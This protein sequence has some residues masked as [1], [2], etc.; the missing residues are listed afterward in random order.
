MKCDRRKFME[1]I[2]R[3]RGQ[4]SRFGNFP[5]VVGFSTREWDCTAESGLRAFAFL[6]SRNEA[7]ATADDA[8]FLLDGLSEH[9]NCIHH[10]IEEIVCDECN[11]QA[12]YILKECLR[13]SSEFI[14]YWCE[15][16]KP[17]NAEKL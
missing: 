4:E 1:E 17:E 2:D 7:N 16:H 6:L 12:V 11:E 15:K 14:S 10:D 13:Y 8:H 5:K 3:L 9:L